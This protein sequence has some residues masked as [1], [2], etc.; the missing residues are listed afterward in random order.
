MPRLMLVVPCYN[1]SEVFPITEKALSDFVSML[2]E[3]G[4]VTANSGILFVNDGSKDNT[5]DLIA[6]AHKTNPFVYGLNL[7]ANV[8][9]QNALLAGLNTACDFCDIAVSIDADLQDDV[10]VIEEMIDKY[11]AGADIVYGVRSERKTDSFFKR[12]T[13]QGFYR[14][15]PKLRKSHLKS[16][17]A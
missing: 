11:E 10:S 16:F 13:A 5:W 6:N 9:H 17:R 4:K 1:E 12:T 15:I 7:S 8:G 14:V 3:K 2:I